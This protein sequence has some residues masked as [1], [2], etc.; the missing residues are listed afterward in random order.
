MLS[1]MWH[2]ISIKIAICTPR[3][4]R[5]F[6]STAQITIDSSKTVLLWSYYQNLSNTDIPQYMSEMNPRNGN[7]IMTIRHHFQVPKP[8]LIIVI[9]IKILSFFFI[10]LQQLKVY[11]VAQYPY[12]TNSKRYTHWSLSVNP[13]WI[14]NLSSKY[15]FEHNP[16]MRIG[17]NKSCLLI[18]NETCR[19]VP[20]LKY[21]NMK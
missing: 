8:S 14:S 15:H 19:R 11:L 2:Q 16:D 20:S 1:L 9:Q 6:D 7:V 13:D 18:E 21:S 4:L 3:D 12:N 10:C 17:G 5:S